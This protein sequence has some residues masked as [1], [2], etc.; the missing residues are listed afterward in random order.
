[1]SDSEALGD[2]ADELANAT[3]HLEKVDLNALRVD[4][5]VRQLLDIKEELEGL[6]LRYRD[7]ERSAADREESRE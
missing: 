5:E 6:C 7:L 1:M 4:D 2:V 3:L